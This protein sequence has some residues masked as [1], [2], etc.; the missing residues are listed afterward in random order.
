MANTCRSALLK[1]LDDKLF[2]AGLLSSIKKPP[3][4]SASSGFLF[5]IT[6]AT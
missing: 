2:I 5:L 3:E 1:F 6:S 4:A